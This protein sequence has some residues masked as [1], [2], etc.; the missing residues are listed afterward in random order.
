MR[1]RLAG[2][3]RQPDFLKLWAGQTVSLFGSQVTT[4]ALPLTAVLVLRAT[5]VQMG[6]LGA[7]QFLPY[8]FLT[9]FAG[10]WVDRRRRRP[11]LI[12]ADVGR[13]GLVGIIPLLALLGVLRM[14]FLYG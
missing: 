12:T 6:I 4:L 2:L 1:W 7:A 13:A 3:W 9:L 10:V 8:L 5:P 14:E 11:M